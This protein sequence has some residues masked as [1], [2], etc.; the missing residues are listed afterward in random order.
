MTLNVCNQLHFKINCNLIDYI[1]KSGFYTSKET[2]LLAL[3]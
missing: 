3:H 1:S 2:L